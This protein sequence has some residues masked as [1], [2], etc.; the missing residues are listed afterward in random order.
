MCNVPKLLKNTA[1]TMK[2]FIADFFS[3]CDQILTKLPVWSHLLKKSVTEN[4]VFC[5]VKANI[6]IK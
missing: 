1:Q 2:F 6:L 5:A 4:F 3:K